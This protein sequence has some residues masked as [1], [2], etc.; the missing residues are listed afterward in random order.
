M[1]APAGTKRVKGKRITRSFIIGSESWPLDDTNRHEGIPKDHTKG[2]RVYIKN[3][4][5]G[6]DITTWLQKVQFKIFH[7]YPNPHRMIDKC[8]DQC[9][10]VRETGWG[11]FNID[12]RLFFQPV[13]HEK[14]QY[15][16]HFL[17]LE[18]YGTE[19]DKLE[20]VE[21]K[22]VR[23][24]IC[25]M[26]E[27]NEPTEAFF[28]ALTDPK[29]FDYLSKDKHK[30]KK[31]V[32]TFGLGYSVELAEQTTPTNPYTK[33]LERKQVQTFEAAEKVVERLMI[34]EKGHTEEMAKRKAA[35][36]E[37]ERKVLAELE[38]VRAAKRAAAA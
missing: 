30:G 4:E 32:G 17:Q 28:N 19:A 38:T 2:W 22:M 25:E 5:G 23:S 12:L 16:L 9:F 14:P 11:G 37:E 33:E 31:G 13:A 21:K 1:P 26:I 6:P 8:K 18:P 3:I 35:L 36:K 10:E 24:E 7:S 20:Q 29:Q 34:E 15:R 27:F